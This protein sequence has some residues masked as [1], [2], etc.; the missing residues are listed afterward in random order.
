MKVI[1]LSRQSENEIVEILL[2]LLTEQPETWSDGFYT[3]AWTPP[4]VKTGDAIADLHVSLKSLL[5]G[6]ELWTAKGFMAF[7]LY[8]PYGMRF[9]LKNKWRL[10]RAVKSARALK[11]AERRDSQVK[12]IRDALLVPTALPDPADILDAAELTYTPEGWM[13]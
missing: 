7:R 5:H 13:Q 8:R 12:A 9:R 6:V 3:F 4:L 2:R 11:A 10:W 1:K